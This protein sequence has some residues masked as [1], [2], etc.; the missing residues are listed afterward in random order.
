MY[1]Y[2]CKCFYLSDIIEDKHNSD[3]QLCTRSVVMASF[4]ASSEL[5]V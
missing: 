4:Y 5:G 2:N 1:F 3:I